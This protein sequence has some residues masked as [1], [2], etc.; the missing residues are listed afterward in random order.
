MEFLETKIIYKLLSCPIGPYEALQH[1]A[2]FREALYPQ[3]ITWNRATWKPYPTPISKL[4]PWFSMSFILFMATMSYLYFVLREIISY[5][6]DSDMSIA[7]NLMFLLC[8][9]V[10][11]LDIAVINTFVFKVHEICFALSNL[12]STKM[13]ALIQGKIFNR[14][15]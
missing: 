1:Y 7:A 6:K 13:M 14:Q 12:G 2:I 3:Y 9:C 8:I 5:E 4:I 11:G 15:A 10:S